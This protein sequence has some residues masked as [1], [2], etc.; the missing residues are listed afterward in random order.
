[1]AENTKIE[2]AHHTF[3]PWIG[4]TKVGA[5]CEH[6]YAESL[7]KRAGHEN[8]GSGMLR[9][10]TSSD[11]WKQ[12]A[13]WQREAEAAG[14]RWRI[15]PSMCDPWDNEADPAV[16]ADF[17]NLWR[18][19][20]NLDW[21]LLSKRCGNA[22]KMVPESWATRWPSNV[23]AGATIATR[24]DMLRDGLKLKALAARVRFWSVEP[25]LGDLGQIPVELMP[26]WVICGGESGGG[27]RPMHP[28]WVLRLLEQ[29]LAAGVPFLFKQWGEW[30]PVSHI[31]S[32]QLDG[33]F[34][35][36]RRRDPEGPRRCKVD[37]LVMQASGRIFP[38]DHW[39]RCH[40]EDPDAGDFAHAAGS[41]SMTMMRIG[42]ARAG[43][44][45]N[46]I[47]HDGVPA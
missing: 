36:P 25:M 15:F 18:S 23:W 6:C 37:Q 41:G 22:P 31:S 3:S 21:L 38:L 10:R 4:C 1:M 32:E 8:W 40:C 9:R 47:Q 34:T 27:A 11:Y 13:R 12:P 2:W 35:P 20:P 14:E 7:N 30:A 46:G 16:R 29:C 44:M 19:T 43:R 5:P 17:L 42:K 24:E 33:L 39:S 45:F 26:D 28:D